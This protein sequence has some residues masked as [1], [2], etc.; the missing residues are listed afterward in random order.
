MHGASIVNEIKAGP[1]IASEE[2]CREKVALETITASACGDEIARSVDAALGEREDVIDCSDLEI[3]RSGA[4]DTTPTAVTH[5]GVLNGAL[6]M[7]TCGALGALGATRSSWKAGETNAVIVSTPGQF[8][9]AGKATPRNGSR[10]RSGASR[11]P[12]KCDLGGSKSEA[13][14]AAVRIDRDVALEADS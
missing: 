7:S 6:L 11:R 12:W 13:A 8:H 14:V 9:L 5:H 10:S 3:Q 2:F 1:G 4:I